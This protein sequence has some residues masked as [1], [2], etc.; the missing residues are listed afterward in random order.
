MVGIIKE[1]MRK[2]LHAAEELGPSFWPYAS[3]SVAD[4]MRHNSTGRLWRQPAFGEPVAV[5]KPGPKKV[6]EPRGPLGQN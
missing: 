3:M 1:H 6:L 5:T 2:V 4:V